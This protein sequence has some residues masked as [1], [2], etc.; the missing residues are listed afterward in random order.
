MIVTHNRKFLRQIRLAFEN[1]RAEFERKRLRFLKV[2]TRYEAAFK[3]Q[4]TACIVGEALPESGEI[5]LGS[6]TLDG[7]I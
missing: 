3:F 7:V 4:E 6:R 5:Q 2:R 1:L